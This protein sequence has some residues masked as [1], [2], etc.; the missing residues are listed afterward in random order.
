MLDLFRMEA[1]S[2]TQVL[3]SGLLAL[4]RD[5]PPADQLESCMRA[6]HSLKG[7]ARIVDLAVGVRVAHAM[8][9][10]FVAAQHGRMML[11]ASTST[12]LLGATDLLARIANTREQGAG[13]E[14][15]EED[16][17]ACLATLASVLDGGRPAIC[18]TR[19]PG[20]DAAAA[21]TS[22][23]RQPSRVADQPRR[24]P[25]AGPR[26]L[27]RVLRVTAENLNRLLG[28]AAS[29]WSSR[30][31]SSRS[32]NRC[33]GSS[34]CTHECADARRRP[35]RG[36][37]GAG[38]RRASR[39]PRSPRC[40][41]R[42]LECQQFLSQRLVELEMF[43]RR[44]LNLVASA[45]RRSARLPHAAVRRRRPGVSAHGARSRALARQAGAARDRRRG[46]AG[47]PRHPGE[48]RAPLGHLLRN[49]VDHGIESPDERRAAG[50]PAEGVV[51]LEARHSAGTL[52]IIV[53]DDGRGVDLEQTARRRRRAE[54]DQR[55]R[56][57]RA[58]SEAELLEFLFLPGF[59]MKEPSPRSP[60]AASASTS[61]RTWS[62][63]CAARCASRRSRAGHA[64][65]AAAAGHA[66]GRSHA[67]RG[68]RRRAVRV[69]ARLTS[70]A[71]SSCRRTR[72]SCSRAAS[73]STSTDGASGWSRRT[74]CS[75]SA[76]RPLAGD[77]LP[78]IV[79]R[80]PRSSLRPRRRPL[81]RR[82]RA[83]RAAARPAARQGQG[84]RRRRAHGGRHARADRRRRGHAALDGQARRPAAA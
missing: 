79:A 55:A 37:P 33:C 19:A 12:L 46:D 56:P 66:L 34:G 38:A 74:R 54:P 63:R 16:V 78:V 70:S 75:A 52:Q 53:S 23:H 21:P 76:S 48:A 26:H 5:T 41:A 69:S 10:C 44:S 2:Q 30:A 61:C 49:A 1:E 35:A 43:D 64:L 24:L 13:R 15:D 42:V 58:L 51:R 28:L 11:A 40:S 82:A 17:E 29:R 72:S 47:R 81:P 3:T 31:G 50:K 65:P 14:T 83:G 32:R 80:R 60:A 25:R 39:K 77:E 7:A 20:R 57:P 27:R 73:I 59:T 9:D 8:E 22:G 45:L 62:S 68:H 84:H 71:R 4:E 18:R 67:A 6:A 36:D